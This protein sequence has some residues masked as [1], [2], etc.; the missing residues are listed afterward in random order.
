MDQKTK[1]NLSL[2]VSAALAVFIG[3]IVR[4]RVDIVNGISG[5]FDS[6][7]RPAKTVLVDGINYR[8]EKSD[9]GRYAY[10]APL[11]DDAMYSGV[12]TVPATIQYRW[13]TYTVSGVDEKAFYDC[14]DLTEVILPEEA[15]WL[16][17]FAFAGSGIQSFRM[18]VGE[19]DA[20][21]GKHAFANCDN[22]KEIVI[23]SECAVLDYAFAHCDGLEKVV[24][25]AEPAG[26]VSLFN[27]DVTNYVRE[28][29]FYGCQSLK[30]VEIHKS[31]FSFSTAGFM[32]D[33]YT[34]YPVFGECPN[35]TEF[36]IDEKCNK[37]STQDGVLF[38]KDGTQLYLCPKSKEGVYRV[39]E[40]VQKITS[41]A[42]MGCTRLTEVY[43]PKSLREIAHRAFRGCKGLTV[44]Y[45]Y[46][47][48]AEYVDD[49]FD[50]DATFY[51]Y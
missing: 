11:K 42:F 21:I 28:A 19:E 32:E 7:S 45:P 48:E 33:T 43:L 16:G 44:Y 49:A 36:I 50:A 46:N 51:P 23:P 5:L 41:S 4:F 20:T 13:R 40:G 38:S 30:T 27:F 14:K 35:L 9:N 6:S 3:L 15:N 10:V 31:L 2:G 22:L 12:V 8:V 34:F 29:A 25:E 24:F 18:P 17:E 47:S 39:P 1:R 37:V 26:H